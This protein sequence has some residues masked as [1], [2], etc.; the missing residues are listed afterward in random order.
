RLNVIAGELAVRA[1][2]SIEECVT[3]GQPDKAW[4]IHREFVQ[5][6]QTLGV[7]DRAIQRV[8][9]VHRKEDEAEAEIRRLLELE[10]K[11]ERYGEEVR[12]IEVD[13]EP[14]PQLVL[15]GRELSE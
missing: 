11:K 6:L 7:V 12:Q 3:Q 9:H 15:A 2:K 5:M 4:R 13:A 10:R 14:A 8:E 1:E